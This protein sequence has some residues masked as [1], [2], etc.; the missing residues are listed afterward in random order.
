MM[1]LPE[2]SRKPQLQSTERDFE[3]KDAAIQSI[4][5]WKY[6]TGKAFHWSDRQTPARRPRG[7]WIYCMI[8]SYLLISVWTT[9][10]I[11]PP[12]FCLW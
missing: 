11:I 5:W 12:N 2:N 6:N 4:P 3:S 8:L 9:I 1:A 7:I 10:M